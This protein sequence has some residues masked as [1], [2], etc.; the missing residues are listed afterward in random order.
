MSQK[1]PC[2]ISLHSVLHYFS[3]IATEDLTFLLTKMEGAE[4]VM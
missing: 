1:M 3:V 2:S 4:E